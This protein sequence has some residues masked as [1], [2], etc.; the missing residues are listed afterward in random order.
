MPTNVTFCN[1]IFNYNS[2]ELSTKDRKKAKICCVILGIFTCGFFHLIHRIC[3]NRTYTKRNN[4]KNS[5]VSKLAQTKILPQ[6]TSNRNRVDLFN[7]ELRKIREESLKKNEREL[8]KKEF[9]PPLPKLGNVNEIV[10]LE[11]SISPHIFSTVPLDTTIFAMALS[12]ASPNQ[13]FGSSY[14]DGTLMIPLSYLVNDEK[15][16]DQ[17]FEDKLNKSRGKEL[18]KKRIEDLNRSV[19]LKE[20]LKRMEFPND[21]KVKH[22]LPAWN[23]NFTLKFHLMMAD[24]LA[25]L[26]LEDL[27]VKFKVLRSRRE[28][29]ALYCQLFP[30]KIKEALTKENIKKLKLGQVPQLKG[31]QINELALDLPPAVFSFISASEVPKIAIEK[32]FN[33]QIEA[34]FHSYLLIQA[35]R[36]D[37]ILASLSKLKSKLS[38]VY[39]SFAQVT[40]IS[41]KLDTIDKGLL[42]K[43]TFKYI[44]SNDNAKL[45]K[46]FDLDKINRYINLFDAKHWKYLDIQK[47]RK[48]NPNSLTKENFNDIFQNTYGG[49]LSEA[50]KLMRQFEP[51]E[52]KGWFQFFE[53]KHWGFL[54]EKQVKAID[55][56]TINKQIFDAIFH[57]TYGEY[58]SEAAKLLRTFSPTQ[59]EAWKQ[60]FDQKHW[61]YLKNERSYRDFLN[62]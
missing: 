2:P 8:L 1:Y 4:Q 29:L 6:K 5:R 42:D 40:E 48:L 17:Y 14:D 41:D 46:E 33:E 52:I 7:E 18:I 28:K 9:A 38:L 30:Q 36:F 24:E 13:I 55:P 34:L 20:R 21:L 54:N 26:K 51:G 56:N 10:G 47:V 39:L 16:K 49:R 31:E 37:Q 15:E 60:Y 35:L 22:L 43:E 45:I 11:K 50:A 62:I 58:Y 12:G 23:Q 53:A 27:P 61:D 59:I 19:Q 3:C 57:E 32:L 44:F 25:D